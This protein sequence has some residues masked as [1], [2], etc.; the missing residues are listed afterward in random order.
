MWPVRVLAAPVLACAGA[1][2]LIAA[3]TVQAQTRFPPESLRNVQAL[4][5]GTSVKQLVETM[6]GFTRAL[7]VRC[8]HC[9][10]GT[11][12]QP[13]ETMDF[14]ADTKASKK[15][16]RQMIRMLQSI[17]GDHLGR[18][19]ERADP[20]V[21]VTCATCHRGITRPRSLIDEL[22]LAYRKGGASA[23]AARFRELREEHY[24]G[25]AYDFGDVAL[26]EVANA[27]QEAGDIP[28]AL[29]LLELNV[30]LLPQSW[31]GYWMLAEMREEAGQTQAAVAALERAV[32]LKPRPDLVKW[33]EAL[34]LQVA[35]P[36]ATGKPK[37]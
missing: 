27:A 18:L 25:D 5:E 6:R 10:V 21:T 24:G 37:T 16:A 12:G 34:R 1:T 31:F 30:E 19:D 29:Q 36:T 26:T 23:A 7:G 9:H 3:A 14:V 28:G 15:T 20:S 2:L 17:N 35:A 11:E 22:L 13:L 33:L 8:T 32:A 4:P